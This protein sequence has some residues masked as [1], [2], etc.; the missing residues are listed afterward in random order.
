MNAHHAA[1]NSL[2]EATGQNIG[3]L[4][5]AIAL[6]IAFGDAVG[7]LI[8]QGAPSEQV[9]KL[10]DIASDHCQS[11]IRTIVEDGCAGSA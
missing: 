6:A 5:T 9:C 2:R 3:A 8:M 4:D 11:T 10:N 7:L 1:L